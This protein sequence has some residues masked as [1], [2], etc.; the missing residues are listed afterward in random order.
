MNI[1]VIIGVFVLALIIGYVVG[2]KSKSVLSNVLFI[3]AVLIL[4]GM[5]F[6]FAPSLA[7]PLVKSGGWGLAIGWVIGIVS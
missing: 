3:A 4:V 5:G 7:L 6:L 1:F 2:E